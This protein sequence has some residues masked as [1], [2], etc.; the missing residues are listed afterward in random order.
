VKKKR[1]KR[2]KKRKGKRR[3]KEEKKEGT[4]GIRGVGREPG[5]ASTRSDAHEKRGRGKVYTVI[6]FVVGTTDRR[7]GFRRIRGSDGKGFRNDLNLAI[8]GNFENYF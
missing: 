1:R 2:K 6:D 8:K 4:G 5:V 3:E 7:E